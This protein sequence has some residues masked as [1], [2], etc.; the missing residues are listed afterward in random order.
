MLISELQKELEEAKKEL[1]DVEVY[2]TEGR[3]LEKIDQLLHR[4]NMSEEDWY[5]C[6]PGTIVLD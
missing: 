3:G 4:G 2:R 1:G 5:Y 6:A